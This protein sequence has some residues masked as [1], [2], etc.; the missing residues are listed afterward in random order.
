MLGAYYIASLAVQDR[1]RTGES[2]NLF[3]MS[4][5]HPGVQGET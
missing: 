4:G 3:W 2:R 1:I 5:R